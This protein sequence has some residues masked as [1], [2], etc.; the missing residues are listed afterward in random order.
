VSGSCVAGA[1]IPADEV[2]LSANVVEAR[3]RSSMHL[4]E[5]TSNRLTIDF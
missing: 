1:G 3:R 2:V 5:F 4:R